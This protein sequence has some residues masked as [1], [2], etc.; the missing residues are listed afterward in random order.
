M[1]SFG[2]RGD[3][4][5][6]ATSAAKR[7]GQRMKDHDNVTPFPKHLVGVKRQ[8]DGTRN[9][10]LPLRRGMLDIYV[11]NNGMMSIDACVPAGIASQIVALIHAAN[12]EV[13]LTIGE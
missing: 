4:L 9:V 2:I 5:T 7:K 12:M 3:A 11:G 6:A 8:I 10:N 13:T 1:T